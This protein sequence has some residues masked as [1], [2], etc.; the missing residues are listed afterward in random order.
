MITSY[1]TDLISYAEVRAAEDP[2]VAGGMKMV[3]TGFYANAHRVVTPSPQSDQV[4]ESLGIPADKVGRWD[5]GVDTKRFSPERRR[6][7]LLPGEVSVLYAGRLTKEKGVELLA[8]AFLAAH[9]K[10]PRLHLCLAGGGPEEE[11]LRERL[12]D[13]VTFLGWLHG[14]VLAEAYASADAFLFASRTDT[15]GQVLQE[16]QASGLPV[17]A[18]AENGPLSIVEDGISGLLRPADAEQ[19]ADALVQVTSDAEL[20]A[21]LRA[22]GLAQVATRSWDACLEQLAGG[23]RAA[24][25]EHVARTATEA[26]LVHAEIDEDEPTAP[27]GPRVVA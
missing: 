24:I 26:P 19:L 27:T 10:D 25:A 23:Y 9:A 15:F 3:L 2:R 16:A 17:I 14:D 12:G 21:K 11:L 5:R 20:A 7:D 4:V 6:D 22:G 18:V 1:H 13:K 8:E